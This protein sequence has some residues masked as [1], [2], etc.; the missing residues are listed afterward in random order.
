[1]ENS[2][3]ISSEGVCSVISEL[4]ELRELW[5]DVYVE[6]G[7][8]RM[9]LH[10]E[11]ISIGISSSNC[12]VGENIVWVSNPEATWALISVEQTHRLLD[13]D[14]QVVVIN[15]LGLC[16]IFYKE[17][18]AHRIKRYIVGHSKV[19]NSVSCHSAIVSLVNGVASNVGFVDSTDHVEM[20]WVTTK[21]ESLTH[22]L[23]LNVLDPAD[24]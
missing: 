14:C 11:P 5:A 13:L 16:G 18:V 19:V 3:T 22:I 23:K 7:P 12:V 6:A 21:F 9:L 15:V 1:M 2:Q 10:I 4:T 8:D 17:S 20:D 24:A